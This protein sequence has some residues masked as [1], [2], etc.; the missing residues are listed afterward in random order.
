MKEN[1]TLEFHLKYLSRQFQ[2]EVTVNSSE[3]K[4]EH[5]NLLSEDFKEELLQEDVVGEDYTDSSTQNFI[6]PK[7]LNESEDAFASAI[8]ITKNRKNSL[9]D[10]N[11]PP[12]SPLKSNL[13]KTSSEM[14]CQTDE[15]K[16]CALNETS[17]QGTCQKMLKDAG[18]NTAKNQKMKW[19]QTDESLIVNYVKKKQTKN[20]KT[21][22]SQ[23][24]DFF[25]VNLSPALNYAIDAVFEDETQR[26]KYRTYLKTL[27]R[28]HEFR[29]AT[30]ILGIEGLA[31]FCD[32]FMRV[33]MKLINFYEDD[34]NKHKRPPSEF[35][36]VMEE[37]KKRVDKALKSHGEA[38]Q[39]LMIEEKEAAL[40]NFAGIVRKQP[41]D[42]VADAETPMTPTTPTKPQLLTPIKTST[43]AK[44]STSKP[45][46]T[47]GSTKSTHT[48]KSTFKKFESAQQSQRYLKWKQQQINEKLEEFWTKQ[49]EL[50]QKIDEED[51]AL[52]KEEAEKTEEN[53]ENKEN[54]LLEKEDAG[55]DILEL[56][57]KECT[58][59]LE[60]K[61]TDPFE[62]DFEV[63]FELNDLDITRTLFSSSNSTTSDSAST[64]ANSFTEKKQPGYRV[65]KEVSSASI[66]ETFQLPPS[67]N[68]EKRTE[69][70]IQPSC[71]TNK[72]E[73]GSLKTNVLA[74]RAIPPP[75]LAF[76]AP[77]PLY[78]INIP[79][80]LI[81]PNPPVNHQLLQQIQQAKIEIAQ[82]N[83]HP[84][85]SPHV[86]LPLSTQLDTLLREANA[87]V[88]EFLIDSCINDTDPLKLHDFECRLCSVSQHID[89][90]FCSNREFLPYL[91][92]YVN[93]FI[94]VQNTMNGLFVQLMPWRRFLDM[95]LRIPER[96]KSFNTILQKTEDSK[97]KDSIGIL[98]N[99]DLHL[100]E[101]RAH[102]QFTR[103]TV[104]PQI[105]SHVRSHFLKLEDEQSRLEAHCSQLLGQLRF[106]F[107]VYPNDDPLSV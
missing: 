11:Q 24:D 106:E 1:T 23:T 83:S 77:P 58:E 66:T 103:H 98:A 8:R 107:K 84:K 20:S 37:Y 25:F 87:C 101:T 74:L 90:V 38:Q 51:A 44:L 82:Q 18:M 42:E 94:S 46:S 30:Q 34:D 29:D 97:S 7:D 67:L 75:P 19:Q 17:D 89:F 31:S 105:S 71:Q 70:E 32:K 3:E 16:E 93:N 35:D 59:G 57:E 49:V 47:K 12:Q 91:Q 5:A 10:E 28:F 65:R 92:H 99:L 55:E 43:P 33:Q 36:K 60:L 2:R 9:E 14:S 64:S 52:A 68:K 4:I 73:Q 81:P 22:W 96:H 62:I 53:K 50:Q 13:K 78:L 102:M 27:T 80:Q 48:T 100:K 95:Q 63:D 88:H 76:N 79:L 72:V 61:R 41:F 45:A 15:Q 104:P 40:D 54:E 6:E 69:K 21:K 26:I 85:F 56:I 86:P 39:L